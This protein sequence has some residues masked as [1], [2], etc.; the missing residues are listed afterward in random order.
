VVAL[1][2]FE[3]AEGASSVADSTGR[4]H[5]LVVGGTFVAEAG[6]A[7]CGQALALGTEQRRVVL[8]DSPT[9]D[10]DTGSVDFWFRVPSE[11]VEALGML[12]R[13]Q[14]GTD[15]PGHLS[16]W[17]TAQ[18]TVTL[19]LQG[20]GQH[21]VRCSEE[22]LEPGAWVHVGF[23]FGSPGTALYV[24]GVL[25]ERTGDPQVET[26]VPECGTETLDGIAGNNLDWLLGSDTARTT[27]P[28]VDVQRHF[29]GGAFDALRISS[30]RRA[31]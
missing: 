10:L 21:S 15:F 25:A 16:I 1:Y 22:P 2:G 17:L 27:Q 14:Q 31:Y 12:G 30:I 29:H 3:D 4:Q 8:P 20:S 11:V 9:W 28:L 5:G 18:R 7:G 24:N 19:R 23:N 6:P 13:D 26:V